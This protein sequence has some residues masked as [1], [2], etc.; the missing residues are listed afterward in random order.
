[1]IDL[2]FQPDEPIPAAADGFG[3]SLPYFSLLALPW[4]CV[5]GEGTT[6]LSLELRISYE[7]WKFLRVAALHRGEGEGDCATEE[8]SEF[9]AME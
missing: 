8:G 6:N 5:N 9:E 7:V 3:V 4:P 1:M 2:S